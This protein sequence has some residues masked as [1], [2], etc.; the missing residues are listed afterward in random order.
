MVDKQTIAVYDDK[1]DDYIKLT[2]APPSKTLLA[3]IEMIPTGSTVL[4]LG[5]GPGASAA[6]MAASGLKVIATD[7]SP[8]MVAVAQSLPGVTARCETYEDLDA[9][10]EYDGI[11]ANFSLL[12]M[13][14]N[15]LAPY[16]NR[17]HKALKPGGLFHLALKTGEGEARDKI[18]RMYSYFS[19]AELLDMLG[20]AGFEPISH[21]EGKEMGLA[22]DIEPFVQILSRA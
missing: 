1:I 22:G 2:K 18:G 11:W 15:D 14:R 21:K 4:D 6:Q 9:V 10:A 3:F 16:M 7:A 5:C 12:H 19:L 13:P 8:E 20:Q 17:L